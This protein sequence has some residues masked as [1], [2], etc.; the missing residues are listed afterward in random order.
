LQLKKQEPRESPSRNLGL[1]KRRGQVGTKSVLEMDWVVT[2]GG[3][4]L[5]PALSELLKTVVVAVTGKLHM[6]Q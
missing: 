1:Q 5:L 6:W 3:A 2:G 4:G